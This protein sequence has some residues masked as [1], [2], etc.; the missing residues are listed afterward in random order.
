MDKKRIH[1]TTAAEHRAL[2]L[3]SMELLMSGQINVPQANALSSLSS[4]VHKS[5]KSEWDMRCYAAEHLSFA[6]GKVIELIGD[7]DG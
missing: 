7:G 4:E 5:I 6:P 2:L 1:V 3:R